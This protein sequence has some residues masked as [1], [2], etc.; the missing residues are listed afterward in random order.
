MQPDKQ[1]E[2]IAK[3]VNHLT[4]QP[5]HPCKTVSLAIA[6]GCLDLGSIYSR[7]L[8]ALIDPSS[9]VSSVSERLVQEY[10]NPSFKM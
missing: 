7:S 2:T 6:L 4:A 9:E 5:F 8:R 1:L 3:N 10:V